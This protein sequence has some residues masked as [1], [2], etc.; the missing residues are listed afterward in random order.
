MSNQ[1]KIVTRTK[2]LFNEITTPITR[3]VIKAELQALKDGYKTGYTIY[4]D[5]E[6]QDLPI[7]LAPGAITYIAAP[8]KHGKTTLL[9]NIFLNILKQYP[10][11]KH[12]FFSF[13][14][15]RC[16]IIIKM[17]MAYI[18]ERVTPESL[19]KEIKK[20]TGEYICF[21]YKYLK[22]YLKNN[23]E[24]KAVEPFID[25]FYELLNSCGL[26]YTKSD[27]D[28]LTT[29]IQDLAKEKDTGC[30]FIDYIQLIPVL[31]QGTMP[32]HEKL[33]EL[34][35][36]FMITAESTKKPIVI[37]TQFN[38][39]VKNPFELKMWNLAEGADIERSGNKIIAVYDLSKQS[40]YNKGELK[41]AVHNGYT[42]DNKETNRK[43]CT[44]IKVLLDRDGE[45]EIEK[46][47]EN[48]LSMRFISNKKPFPVN[49]NWSDDTDT[50]TKPG[51][52]KLPMPGVK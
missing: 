48:D 17:L 30:M 36:Q 1:E 47:V 52:K 14:E 32:L 43:N 22:N 34:C 33:K 15:S 20:E 24:L 31:T 26:I 11:E 18:R 10:N 42:G 39:S 50:D 28:G 40:V 51:K 4:S 2:E 45:S 29:L 19:A 37:A 38:R 44:L 9:I 16:S 49:R 13:E 35:R 27:I 12:Y 5:D 25:Q 23:L 46:I 21:N 3:E 6:K 7:E 41:P 8:P